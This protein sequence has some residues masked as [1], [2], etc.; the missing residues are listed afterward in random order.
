MALKNGI[1][2]TSISAEPAQA[3]AAGAL[4]L[5]K[6]AIVMAVLVLLVLLGIRLLIERPSADTFCRRGI[7]GRH[8]L[9]RHDLRGW[10]GCGERAGG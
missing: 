10:R 2:R 6:M 5:I 3:D 4:G 1:E 9:R 7:C 8:I